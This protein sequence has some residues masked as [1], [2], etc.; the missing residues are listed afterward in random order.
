MYEIRYLGSILIMIYVHSWIDKLNNVRFLVSNMS[1]EHGCPITQINKFYPV[2]RIYCQLPTFNTRKYV[3]FTNAI[4]S[5][6]APGFPIHAWWDIFLHIMSGSLP[7]RAEVMWFIVCFGCLYFV[8]HFGA[9]VRWTKILSWW[10]RCLRQH[11]RIHDLICS[12]GLQTHF[13]STEI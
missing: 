9:T 6:L 5:S 11:V 4:I 12:N 7:G 2:E 3:W 10:C 1:N 8:R 13:Y